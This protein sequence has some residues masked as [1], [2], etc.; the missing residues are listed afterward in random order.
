[1]STSEA[2]YDRVLALA[3]PLERHLLGFAPDTHLNP[4]DSYTTIAVGSGNPKNAI[5]IDKNQRR[6]SFFIEAQHRLPA[7]KDAGINLTPVPLD[8]HDYNKNKFETFD[9]DQLMKP[10]NSDIVRELVQQSVAVLISRQ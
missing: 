2:N 9:V 10:E 3:T 4:T 1:M 7:Y 6:I 8:G 5:T